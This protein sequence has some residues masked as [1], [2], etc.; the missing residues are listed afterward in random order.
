[1]NR[2]RL[3]IHAI[4]FLLIAL[5]ALI[6][7]TASLFSTKYSSSDRLDLA[8]IIHTSYKPGVTLQAK[9]NGLTGVSLINAKKP[10][11]ARPN[12]QQYASAAVLTTEAELDISTINTQLSR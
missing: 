6:V 11:P 4:P 7:S 9:H 2:K 3:H 5:G 1:M 10:L 12:A 8:A